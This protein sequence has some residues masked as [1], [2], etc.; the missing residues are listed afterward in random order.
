MR[1][2]YMH[3]VKPSSLHK[4]ANI[5]RLNECFQK[6]KQL[7]KPVYYIL[8][9]HKYLQAARKRK[10]GIAFKT[11]DDLADLVLKKANINYFPVSESERTL[12]FQQLMANEQNRFLEKPE[13]LRH[14]AKAYAETYGQLKRIGLKVEEIPP[15]FQQM[16]LV[17]DEYETNWVKNQRLLDPENRIHEAM[18]LTNLQDIELGGIVIDGYIDFSTLQ[19]MVIDFFV[20]LDLDITVYLPKIKDANIVTETEREL[21]KLGFKVVHE[22]NEE[23]ELKNSHVEVKSATSVDEEINGVLQEIALNCKDVPYSE[24]GIVLADERAYLEKLLKIAK[25]TGIPYKLPQKK[26][27]TDTLFFQFIYYS[28]LKH[29]GRFLT[30]WDRLDI[31]DTFLRLQFLNSVDYMNY[32]KAYIETGTLHEQFT[33][34]VEQFIQ[35]RKKAPNKAS[36]IE[37][38]QSLKEF[39]EGNSFTSSW[40]EQIS[41]EGST[42]KLQQI[43]LE[44]KAYEQICSFLSTKITMLKEQGLLDLHVHYHIFVD[45]LNEGLQSTTIYIDREPTTGIQIHSF[46][47]VAL[48]QGTSLYVLGMNEGKFP[49]AHKLSGY[50]QESDLSHLPIPFAS[51]TRRLFRE[52]DDALFMQL[53]DVAHQL[54]FSYVV[55]VDPHNP[56]LPSVYLEQ[57][58]SN[59][60]Q[61][62]YS[63]TNRFA[64][65]TSFSQHDYEEK[66]SYHHGIGKNVKQLPEH[67][68]KKVST[69]KY[70]EK[71]EEVVSPAW[72]EKLRRDVIPVT[73]L[74]SYANCP[75]KFALE[76][77]LRVKEPKEKQTNLDFRDVGSMLHTII[78]KF[79]KQ[80]DLIGKPF[81][82]FSEEMKE[83]AEEALLSIFEEEWANV[84]AGHLD[85][86]KLQL[87]IEKE[88]WLK[89]IKK[90]W[91]A[92]KK[93]FWENNQLQQMYL[94]RLE[95]KVDI[96]I[97]IDDETTMMLSGKIDRI[98][99][100]EHGFVI[101]DYKSGNATLNFPKEVR[102]GLK[103]QL[104]LYLVAMQK[105]LENGHYQIDLSN[106]FSEAPS[107]LTAH[108]A[109]YISLRE[110]VKRAGNSVWREE[111]FK[112]KSPFGVN[113]RATKE[114]TLE[115]E[116]LLAK[117]ELKQRIKELWEGSRRDF[118]VKPLKCMNSCVYKAVCR[119][120]QEQIEQGEGEWK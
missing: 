95:E 64:T 34:T 42:K 44:W 96:D 1:S 94:F 90:W 97:K 35:F 110:P 79:Y 120:T 84:E 41:A 111:H 58:K 27:L 16:K 53:F 115:A 82:T 99:I 26:H 74:E 100:D 57:W 107:D 112:S 69:L 2:D 20:K 93:H 10:T 72:E 22:E 12:F 78:E 102:P 15:H 40:K 50:L 114:E 18:S 3:V 13:E 103:L 109:S 32:K 54:S 47:D 67:L 98:D 71:G 81:A 28:L 23:T 48:F 83:T 118:S 38:L 70:L 56:L 76:R 51:P 39:L 73:M 11:F 4:I 49:K 62:K 9:S 108:G 6:Q 52:K 113:S 55:G 60:E 92:E 59:I 66:L 61:R 30:R 85:F 17:F 45:W 46:R 37:Y 29:N 106:L 21:A 116:A 36:L 63:A 31:I 33:S 14:K 105:R 104:P 88:E 24:V 89:K 65:K 43:R 25:E 117:Y 101:Y 19:Y 77:I 86:S 75:F 91:L 119:V 68:K 7:S 87:S 80:L 5:D 8:P